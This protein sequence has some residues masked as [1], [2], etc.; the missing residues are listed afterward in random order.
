VKGRVSDSPSLR[1]PAEE[2]RPE[3]TSGLDEVG[4]V[5]RWN[6][7]IYRGIRKPFGELYSD[8]FSSELGEQLFALGLVP[9]EITGYTLEGYALVLKHQTIPV[10]S[11]ASEWCTAMFKDAASVTCDIQSKLLQSG[12]T[13]KDAHPWNVLFDDTSPKFVDIGSIAKHEPRKVRF[14]LKDFRSTFLY[15]L[16]LRR[17]GLAQLANAALVVNLGVTGGREGQMANTLYRAMRSN[18]PST[19]WAFHRFHEYRINRMWRRDPVTALRR[20][21]DQVKAIPEDLLSAGTGLHNGTL[22]NTHD[23]SDQQRLLDQILGQCKPKSALLLGVGDGRDA[24]LAERW[25]ARVLAADID[26]AR[27]NT[28]YRHAAERNLKILPLRMDINAPNQMHGPWGICRAA[29]TRF[30][31]DLVIILSLASHL[32]TKQG[33]S[34]AQVA[35]YL[36]AFSRRSA[37]VQFDDRRWDGAGS[38]EARHQVEY[39]LNSFREHLRR[40][41]PEVMVAQEHHDH[42]KVLIC[43][44]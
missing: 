42:R 4:Q 3:P 37:I 16:L 13:L 27:L 36:A 7:G 14:F 11:Y 18:M 38:W 31:S 39:S 29:D 12:Y 17:S 32:L 40:H 9:T 30:Q 24:L 44:R 43:H 28:L 41:F 20:L 33:I 23:L 2:T 19:E 25:G 21:R 5:F 1:I 6:G 35:R 26:D 10:V 8:I 22:N 15:P 34:F